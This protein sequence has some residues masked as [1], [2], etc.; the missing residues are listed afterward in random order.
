MLRIC[1]ALLAAQ[2]G[3]GHAQ[4]RQPTVDYWENSASPAFA[5]IAYKDHLGSEQA[6]V[7]R[8]NQ[9]WLQRWA[10]SGWLKGKRVGD[11]GIGAGL[12]AKVLAANHS[13]AHYV[14]FDIATRSLSA[15][16]KKLQAETSCPHT[17]ILVSG[18]TDFASQHLDVLI[19][20]QVIQHFPSKEYTLAWLAAI[21][22]ARIPKVLLEVRTPDG[23]SRPIFNAWK[24]SRTG[25][26]TDD[27]SFAV[28]VSC[29]WVAKQLPSYRLEDSW[30]TASGSSPSSVLKAWTFHA[31]A[32]SLK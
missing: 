24:S 31:C 16:S 25:L 10:G 28:A 11:Y 27:V 21:E 2:V 14:G 20:Q 8:W 23:Q 17:L 4:M 9:Q 18:P 1:L 32:F 13:I 26:T 7:R 6:M 5:H 22:S 30:P 29:A 15:A 19:C 3:V 12:L